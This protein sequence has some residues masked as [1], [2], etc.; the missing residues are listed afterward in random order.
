MAPILFRSRRPI[1]HHSTVE[2]ID[3]SHP[4]GYKK[5]N[6]AEIAESAIPARL[7]FREPEVIQTMLLTEACMRRSLGT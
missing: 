5:P 7:M 6:R 4:K 1:R 2:N 3:I